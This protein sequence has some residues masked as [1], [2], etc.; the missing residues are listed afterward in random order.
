MM[1]KRRWLLGSLLALGLA[2][3]CL[4]VP[5]L[6]PENRLELLDRQGRRL[7]ADDNLPVPLEQISAWLIQATLAA[8]DHRFYSHWGVDGRASLAAA[9]QNLRSGRVVAGGSTLTQQ[10]IANLSGRPQSVTQKAW[11]SLQALRLERSLSKATILEHYLNHIPYGN[12]TLGAESAARYYFGRPAASLSLAQAAFLAGVPRGPDLYNPLAHFDKAR[13]RQRW[14]LGRMH[15]LGWIDIDQYHQALAEPIRVSAHEDPLLAPHFCRQVERRCPAGTV[16][17]TLDGEVQREVEGIVRTQVDLLRDRGLDGAA[18]VVLD[19]ASGE[20]RA[21]VG[22]P[23]FRQNQVDLSD[24]R[25]Q[26]GSALKP[27]TY[28]MA[29]ESGLSAADLIPDLPVHYR[30]NTGDFAPTNYDGQFHGPVRLRTALASS[31]NVPAVRIAHRVGVAPL[32]K[33]LQQLGLQSL[34]QPAQHYGL[35]LTLGSGEVTL[36]ELTRAYMALANG[37]FYRQEVWWK[38]QQTARSQRIFSPQIAFLLSDILK[39]PAARAPAFGHESVLA[40]PFDCAVKT[41]TSRDYSDN[42]TLGFS[43]RYTVGVWAGPIAGGG[44]QDVSGVA[45]AGPIFREVMLALHRSRRPEPFAVPRGLKR[46]TVCSASGQAPGPYCQGTLREWLPHPIR[47]KCEM[48]RSS[49]PVY[50]HDYAGWAQPQGL[51]VE[52]G[53]HIQFPQDGDTFVIDPRL[54]R[55]YQT[56]PL[57]ASGGP[58]SWRVDGHS[59]ASD[60][61]LEPGPHRIQAQAPDGTTQEIHITVRP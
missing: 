2:F 50:G 9:Y 34:D 28:G 57:Q 12:N 22:S 30:T 20:V 51:A 10:L 36:L 15:T 32:L 7:R 53:L 61:P 48:H 5:S 11:Q 41:G 43:T 44:M 8:E 58:V 18:V 14:V 55:R 59:V 27:F 52:A 25:R 49:G 6:A 45:G 38:G 1:Q 46:A 47:E 23:D 37:G 4:P 26:P 17:T 60:W 31:Y 54:D 39:D 56:L 3:Y 40:L 35:S 16:Q 33:R 29:L 19:N 42:W 24:A 21:L 13:E